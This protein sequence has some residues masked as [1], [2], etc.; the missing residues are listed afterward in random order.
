[1]SFN[2][3][4]I[5]ND[6]N[7][8]L[9]DDAL[10]ITSVEK[11]RAINGAIRQLNHDKSLSIV[12]DIAGD[13]TQDY[14]LPS[15]FTKGFSDIQ[16]VEVPAGENPPRLRHRDDDW[17]LYE[18]PT[19]T[20]GEQQR[21]RF[22][23]VTPSGAAITA[24]TDMDVD[25]ISFQS[26][27]TIRYTFN[28][29][30]DLSGV[31]IGDALLVVTATTAVN[32]GNFFITAVNDGSNFVDVT[33]FDRSS[34]TDDEAT[35]SPA[36]GTAKVVDIIRVTYK[37]INTV[38]ESTSTLNQD[39]FQAII[40]KS[41]VFLF[42]ALAARFTESTDP[43]ILI[44]SV[45]LGAKAQGYLFLAERYEKSYNQITGLDQKVKASQ[46]MAEADIVFAHGEDF[47]FHPRRS[48]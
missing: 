24:A 21:L 8:L 41:L 29:T 46:A 9:K 44:D 43:S 22:F 47:L 4:D 2:F 33:N 35:D 40:Y 37:S 23:S 42:R 13:G 3:P 34:N 38:T 17:R 5:R 1:M 30:P 36:V 31:S 45:D 48:R 39:T 10:L 12:R 15:D 7:A 32:N 14:R 6:V 11:D 20:T 28:G 18:D 26:G 25:T 16:E 19:K 27:N